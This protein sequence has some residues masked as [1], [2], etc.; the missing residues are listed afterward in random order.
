MRVAAEADRLR[1]SGVRVLDFAA[2]E[3]DFAT[4]EHI[5]DAARKALD[6]HFTKYTP[7]V[8]IPELREAIAESYKDLYGVTYSP[9]EVITTAGGKQ[10]LYNAAMTLFGQGD[11]VITHA[12]GW[13]TIAEQI[14]LA[15]AEPV[16]VR[17][18]EED[19]FALHADTFLDAITP[20]TRG[21]VINSPTNPTGALI[22][23]DD[24]RPIADAAAERGLWV[25]LDLCYERLI[26]DNVPHNLPRILVDRMR[27]RTVLC[28]SMSKAYAMTGWRC[29]WAMGPGEVIK[30]CNAIQSNATSNVNS[31]TQKAAVAALR[32]PQDCLREML[33]EYRV[34][35][36]KLISWLTAD[37]P[38]RVQTPAGTFFL[39]VD[40]SDV[41]SPGGIRTSADFAQL[42][43]DETRVVLV[44]GEAFDAPGFVRISYAASLD[45]LREASERLLD[46]VRRHAEAAA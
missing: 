36:D 7:T 1:R 3:P 13:P 12:P 40:V 33:D 41:L 45:Q 15:E 10:A 16:I 25:I 26:Y 37:S 35:R 8:G 32:G 14:K 23:E 5:V 46:F 2:G 24:M 20:R 39:F 34:R 28:G 11:E 19:G 44:P 18:H 42:L 21:I 22:S 6:E 27:D 29:G 17:S 30:A 31:I 9:A 43:L 4:P 38:L